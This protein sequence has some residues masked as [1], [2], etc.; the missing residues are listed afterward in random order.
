MATVDQ[1]NCTS[2]QP[3]IEFAFFAKRTQF[4]LDVPWAYGLQI[5]TYRE[6]VRDL[7]RSMICLR[8]SK[9]VRILQQGAGRLTAATDIP[10]ANDRTRRSP[11]VD[12]ST[13]CGGVWE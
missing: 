1:G 3:Q 5:F 12:H 4:P 11:V 7:Q 8:S 10:S 6:G 9:A 13:R 2:A